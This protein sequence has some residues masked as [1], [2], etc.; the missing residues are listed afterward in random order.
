MSIYYDYL[1]GESDRRANLVDL[2]RRL[3]YF[4]SRVHN[5]SS[6]VSARHAMRHISYGSG[7]VTY[8]TLPRSSFESHIWNS[9]Q[10]N[11]R[12]RIR[13]L[14]ISSVEVD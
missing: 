3:M 10:S 13:R 11:G 6:L 7:E 8:S 2:T 1:A 4:Y 12:R 5:A 9:I 14:A